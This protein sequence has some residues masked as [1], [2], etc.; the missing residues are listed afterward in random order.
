MQSAAGQPEL[1]KAMNRMVQAIEHVHA[2]G[3]VHMDVK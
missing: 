1:V 2:E 3:F